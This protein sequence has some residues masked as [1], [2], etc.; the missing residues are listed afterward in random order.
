MTGNQYAG[1]ISAH[2]VARAIVEAVGLPVVATSANR[3]GYP[4]CRS[5]EDCDVVGIEAA[6]VVDA[7][8]V[9]GE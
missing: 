2:P 9:N 8:P 4:A 3:S 7:A 5:V 6:R 1:Q